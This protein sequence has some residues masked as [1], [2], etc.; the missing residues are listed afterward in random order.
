MRFI[1][2]W[3]RSAKA[4]SGQ[5]AELAAAF[6]R[7]PAC[8]VPLYSGDSWQQSHRTWMILNRGVT[9]WPRWDSNPYALAGRGF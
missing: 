6:L 5:R 4:P 3:R 9:D 1:A 2:V 8:P 7:I